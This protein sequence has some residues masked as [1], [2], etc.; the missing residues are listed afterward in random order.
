MWASTRP[1][2]VMNYKPRPWVGWSPW[3][4]VDDPW[5]RSLPVGGGLSTQ[6]EAKAKRWGGATGSPSAGLLVGLVSTASTFGRHTALLES[7][8]QR[9]RMHVPGIMFRTIS[10]SL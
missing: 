4:V 10:V 1:K 9:P 6:A 7:V 8:R 5:V 2:G 3:A